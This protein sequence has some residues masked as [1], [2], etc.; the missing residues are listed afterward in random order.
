MNTQAILKYSVYLAAVGIGGF[1]TFKALQKGGIVSAEAQQMQ[2]NERGADGHRPQVARSTEATYASVPQPQRAVP[3]LRSMRRPVSYGARNR[4]VLLASFREGL[5]GGG[6]VG[7]RGLSAAPGRIWHDFGTA[8][9][10]S[11]GTYE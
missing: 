1:I 5:K 7:I 10:P 4:V 3:Q 9:K 8:T 6:G 2:A 11:E